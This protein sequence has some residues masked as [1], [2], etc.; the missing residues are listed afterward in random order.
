MSKILKVQPHLPTPLIIPMARGPAWEIPDLLPSFDPSIETLLIGIG[1]QKS[2][3]TWMHR[4]LSA[5]PEIHRAPAK[6]V[7]YWSERI[8]TSEVSSRVRSETEKYRRAESR[9]GLIERIPLLGRLTERELKA[10]RLRHESFGPDRE[11]SL[12]AYVEFL[13]MRRGKQRIVMD[14]TPTYALLPHQAYA[15]M[16]RLHPNTKFIFLIRD[17]VARLWSSIGM[18]LK[19]APQGG[20][21]GLRSSFETVA[22][23]DIATRTSR[24]WRYSE[25]DKTLAALSDAGVRDQTLVIFYEELFEDHAI[26]QIY[27]FLAIPKRPVNTNARINGSKW[28]KVDMPADLRADLRGAFQSTYTAVEAEMGYLPPAWR[29]G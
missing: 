27:N 18:G 1:A 25:Y 3:T 23:R 10:R 6:E 2:G 17:P 11:R 7:H 12:Q 14:I 13:S 29:Q 9:L 16:A 22:R 15:A 8:L 20:T 21:D 28:G 4:V 19:R 5:H 26:D 24:R